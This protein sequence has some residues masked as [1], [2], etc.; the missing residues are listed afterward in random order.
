VR[1]RRDVAP[2]KRGQNCGA[3]LTR[4]SRDEHASYLRHNRR[5]VLGPRVDVYRALNWFVVGGQSC[6]AWLE[7]DTWRR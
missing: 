3:E 4:R 2:G 7:V 6:G 5:I 1:V